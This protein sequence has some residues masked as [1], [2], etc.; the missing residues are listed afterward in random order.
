[1]GELQWCKEVQVLGKIS[2]WFFDSGLFVEC[3]FCCGWVCI[4]DFWILF[5]WKDIEYFKNKGDLYCWVVFLLL[6]LGEYI[7]DIEMILVDRIFIDI[8]FQSNVFF[9]EV[10][11]DF[12][13]WLELYGVCVEEEGVL[14]GGFKRFVIKFSSFLGCFF[15]EACSGIVGQC[16][17]FREQFYFVFYFSCWWFLL[18]FFGLYYIYF[19][20]SVRW[21][22]YI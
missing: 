20:S 3:F 10:G 13:L 12:E 18:L 4:F 2:W 9:V 19:G 15:R 17:G 16:W 11:L 14:I 6:Q 5:M 21:I 7:Q 1:M 8:F 22:L